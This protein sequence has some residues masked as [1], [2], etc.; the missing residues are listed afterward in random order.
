MRVPLRL[1]LRESRI[2][3]AGFSR[4]PNPGPGGY[5]VVLLY[6]ENRREAV[7]ARRE[8]VAQQQTEFV[9]ALEEEILSAI[10]SR[11]ETSSD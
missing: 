4:K 3:V 7:R 6:G 9:S 1:G 10:L 5:G 11:Q 8:Q 2:R